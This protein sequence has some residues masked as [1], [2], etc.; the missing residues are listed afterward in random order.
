MGVKNLFKLIILLLPVKFFAQLSII[1]NGS[2]TA[3]AQAITGAG[4]TVSSASLNCGPN[5]AGTF[6]YTG[7]NLGIGSGILLTTGLATD[8]ANAGTYFCSVSNGN[9]FH[10]PDLT[11]ISPND[12]ND[13]CILQFDFVPICDTVKITFVF[14]SEEYPDYVGSYNDGFGIFLTGP[15]PGGG[16]YTSQNIGIL[17][18]PASVP[19]SINNVNHG[20]PLSGYPPTNPTFFHDNYTSPNSDIA[21]DGYTIPI[22]SATP[23]KPCSTYH[24]KIAI[25]DAIDEAFDSGVFVGGNA[26]SCSTAPVITAGNTSSSCG[27]SNGSVSVSVT[28]YTGTPT[29]TWQPGGQTTSTVNNLPAGTYTCIVSLLTACA[30]FTQSVITTIANSGSSLSVSPAST[31]ATCSNSTNGS[32]TVTISGGS[33]PYATTWNTTPP[34]SGTVAVNLAPG[35]YVATVTDNTGCHFNENVTVGVTNVP[36][37]LTSIVQVCGSISILTAP[38]GSAY[39]WY[40]SSGTVIGGATSSTYN[41]TGLSAGQYYLVGYTDNSTTCRDS[42]KIS[43][44]EYNLAFTPGPPNAPCGGGNNGSLSFSP[45]PTNTFT[46]FNWSLNGNASYTCAS[47]SPNPSGPAINIGS[48]S[49]GTYTIVIETAGN[50]SCGYTYT[51]TLVAGVIAVAPTVTVSACG[52]DTAKLN[53]SVSPGSTNNWYTSSLVSLGSTPGGTPLLL[54]PPPH[55]G[56]VNTSGAIYIDSVRNAAHCLSVYKA[57]IQKTSFQV[58]PPS[59]LQPLKCHNDSI[60][61]LKII[62][63]REINGPIGQPYHFTWHYPAPYNSP[64]TVVKNLPLPAF[65]TETNLHAGTYTC[66]I[67]AGNCKDSIIYTFVNPT[68]LPAD[69]IQGYYCPKDSLGTLVAKPGNTQY[70]W[71]L[72]HV[73]VTASQNPN[74][75]K[76]SINVLVSDI[77][78][79]WATYFVNGCR[80]TA[81]ILISHAAYNAFL[82]STAVNIFTP[83]GDRLNDMFYP[84]YDKNKSPYQIN[85]QADLYQIYIYNRWGK[86]VF[87]SDEYIKAWDG[88]DLNGNAADDGTYF[89]IAKYKSNCATKADIV[90]QKGYIQLIR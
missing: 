44:S 63:P 75:N 2:A 13:V 77:P 34:Q 35:T 50:P 53:P 54:Y 5:A 28:S 27:A 45:A 19:V 16:N 73:V 6:T 81:K 88:K 72:N 87:E 25:A 79:Y 66:V 69:T 86:L 37:L 30:T 42:M 21:Y 46:T 8:V 83:N 33:A 84:F 82:P 52:L 29:Y 9:L 24:M 11:S 67:T 39:Q 1:P 57:Y 22:T 76:D 7:S 58:S 41:A 23:V 74:Y 61:K 10:D 56:N 51:Y 89:Y 31:N 40:T 47:C 62:V 70:N 36:T 55:T 65:S 90:T 15:K 68:A 80:D 60:G 71:L 85:K 32:A 43:I 38:V 3:L 78:N 26:V 12:T 49:G 64:A 18:P 48:L 17:P 20:N 59:V 4:V 14:G